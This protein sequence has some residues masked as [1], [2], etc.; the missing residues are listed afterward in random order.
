V[1]QWCGTVVR[2][3]GA[4]QWCGTVVRYSGA[5]QWC[6]TVVRH[7]GAVQWYGTVVRYSGAVQWCHHNKTAVRLG[8]LEFSFVLIQYLSLLVFAEFCCSVCGG[9][10]IFKYV[11]K[12][13]ESYCWLSHV[14]PLLLLSVCLS[15][16]NNFF[17]TRRIFMKFDS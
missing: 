15:A 6:G 10:D 2:H 12:T 9:A 17:P 16:Y 3:S 5:A 14:C 1:A 4:V 11:R 13:E 8:N 7:S